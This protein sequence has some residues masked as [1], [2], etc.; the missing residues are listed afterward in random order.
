MIGLV[1]L[2][3]IFGV[4]SGVFANL[5]SQNFGNDI[6]KDCFKRIMSLSF[7]QTDQFSTGS[8]VTRVTNDIT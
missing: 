2:G 4:L 6:R 8:L 3:G 5:C 1:L 7:E